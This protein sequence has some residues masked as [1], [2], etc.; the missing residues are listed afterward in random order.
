MK[1]SNVTSILQEYDATLSQL[2]K[3]TACVE[4]LL[5]R[6]LEENQLRVHS[7]TS[8]VKGRESLERKINKPDKNYAC[9]VDI[10]DISGIR[11]ITY[12][13]DVVDQISRI[14]KTE[15]NVDEINSIDKRQV[16]DPDRFGYL[17]VHYVVSLSPERLKLSEYK[18]YAGLKC[19]VQIRSILQHA[20]AEIEHDLG[21]KTPVE[22]PN[23]IKRR[24]FKLAGLLEIADDEFS[25]IRHDLAAYE[26]NVREEIDRQPGTVP[27][28]KT[29][30]EV[31]VQ[32]SEI[33]QRIAKKL[34]KLTGCELDPALP[35]VHSKITEQLA[36][37][38]IRTIAELRDSLKDN[39]E[40]VIKMGAAVLGTPLKNPKKR[41]GLIDLS[42]GI[43]YLCYVLV[44][45]QNN[46]EVARQYVRE[47]ISTKDWAKWANDL[48]TLFKQLQ[49]T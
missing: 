13:P 25:R 16:L 19:E 40:L 2:E 4:D 1:E 18:R 46:I 36:F 12:L 42:I 49:T 28:N 37:C 29:S 11:I 14:I 33:V 31:F 26:A 8:R 47:H 34:E 9:L 45:K 23:E 35:Y 38:G 39:E 48:M 32:S 15:F 27:I 21:Y 5:K 3:F 6:L 7:V 30:V 24:F 44:L 22:I 41:R 43:F 20:W 17:S 10:T